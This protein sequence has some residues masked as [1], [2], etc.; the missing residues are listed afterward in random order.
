MRKLVLED[1]HDMIIALQ[2]EISS[3]PDSRYDHRLHGV[4]QVGK[5]M[6]CYEVAELLGHGSRTIEYWVKSFNAHGFWE[7]VSYM[8]NTLKPNVMSFSIDPPYN[9]AEG[10]GSTR[11]SQMHNFIV[12]AA[13]EGITVLAA[14][15]DYGYSTDGSTTYTVSLDPYAI[16]VGGLNL[17]FSNR[18]IS[19]VSEW[20]SSGGGYV[21]GNSVYSQP[22]YQNGV[23]P[24][25]GYRDDPDISFA[26]APSIVFYYEGSL[27]GGYVGTSFATPM[28]S[29][30]T[31]DLNQYGGGPYGFINP[32]IYDIPYSTGAYTDITS[33]NNGQPAGSGWDYVT[34]IGSV[35]ANTFVQEVY[36][37]YA[38]HC[39]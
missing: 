20:D 37:Y 12:Q 25:N 19:S 26:A 17:G 36:D 5:G 22:S 11:M 38:C 28:L 13:D 4:I 29:G 33:G 15:G 34:G 9:T 24:N 31:A 7:E 18:Q 3:T 10:Y 16:S 27:Q 32:A 8:V 35:N 30:V 39:H 2:N 14:S 1:K 23:V 21:T 6:S